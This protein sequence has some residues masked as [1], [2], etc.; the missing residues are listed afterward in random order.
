MTRHQLEA[1]DTRRF[2]LKREVHL[3]VALSSARALAAELGFDDT[4]TNKICTAVSEL[5]RNIFKYAEHGDLYLV[6]L[7]GPRGVGFEVVATDRGPGIDDPEA[8][9]R[10]NFSTQ[11]TLGLGLP[12][13]RRMADDFDLAST[14]GV[15]T[16]VTIRFWREN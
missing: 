5:G 12:G 10:D 16:T 4:I 15:G 13:V 9:L 11:G 3:V 7:D 2:R 1:R 14:P 8:A 6:H